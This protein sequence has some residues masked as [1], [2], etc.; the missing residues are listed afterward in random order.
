M[1]DMGFL[2]EI[3]RI[4]AQLPARRQTLFFSATMPPPIAALAERD[5]ARSGVDPATQ[6]QSAPAAGITQAV[7]PVP[8]ELK[9]SLIVHLLQQQDDDPGAGLHADQAPRQPAGGLAGPGRHPLPS[10]STATGR[11]RSAPRRWPGSRAARFRCSSP[12]TSRRAASTSS[13]R[14]RRELRR[15]AGARRLH[16]SRRPHRPRGGDRRGV[17]VR[18]AGRGTAISATSSARSAAACRASRCRTSTTPRSRRQARDPARAAHRRD[19]RA[20]AR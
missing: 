18:R 20:Q 3:R 5:A 12:P 10:A 11:R 8:Q 19:P 2:P 9:S 7:Y 4:L 6:R 16:P 17:H 13:A 1:L 14:P 15:A